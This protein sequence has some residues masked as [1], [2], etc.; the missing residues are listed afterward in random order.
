MEAHFN[1]T[2]LD[3]ATTKNALSLV[4]FIML[5]DVMGLTILIPVTPYIVQRYSG[6]ALMV[7]LMTAI[8]AAAQFFAAPLL[9]KVS[10]RYG[11]RPVLLASV[12]GSA[13]GYLMFG[14]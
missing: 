6:D 7:T 12:F 8:Y 11:R 10:D 1:S 9:G 3:R 2:P 14:F 5:L 4:F 13:I